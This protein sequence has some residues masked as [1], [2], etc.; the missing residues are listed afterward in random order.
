[1][2]DWTRRVQILRDSWRTRHLCVREILKVVVPGRWQ[3]REA[4]ESLCQSLGHRRLRLPEFDTEVMFPGFSEMPVAVSQLPRGSWS[5]PLADQVVL[6][7]IVKVITAKVILEVGSFRGY[8]ARVLAEN[9][10]EDSVIHCVDKAPDHGEAYRGRGIAAKIRRYVGTVDD[11]VETTL[12]GLKFDLI[13][14]D[15]DHGLA[16]VRRDTSILLPLLA[17]GGL[18]VWH[19]YAD[20]G[21][22]SEWNRVPEVLAELAATLPILAIPGSTLAVH[23]KTWRPEHI[24]LAQERWRTEGQAS[25]WTTERQRG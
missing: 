8:T 19:D 21:W 7:K 2:V 9:V 14:L 18:F 3:S 11:F 24:L 5:T 4:L 20:W 13:F 25:D 15:A 1:M 17:D 22:M 16:A 6:T 12:G 23:G 10:N